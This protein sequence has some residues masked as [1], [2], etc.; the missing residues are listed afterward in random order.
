MSEQE[1][2]NAVQAVRQKIDKGLLEEAKQELDRLYEYKPVRLPWMVA[3]AEWKLKSGCPWKEVNKRL[4]PDIMYWGTDYEGMEKYKDYIEKTQKYYGEKDYLRK[5]YVTKTLRGEDVSGFYKEQETALALCEAGL[6][7]ESLRALAKSL[8]AV[9]ELAAYLIVA[10]ELER[11][12]W[13]PLDRNKEFMKWQNYGY[14]E[15]KLKAW[16]SGGFLLVRDEKNCRLISVLAKILAGMKHKVF[17]LET[18]STMLRQRHT[19]KFELL[20]SCLQG[21]KMLDGITYIP[22]ALVEEGGKNTGSNRAGIIDFICEGIPE[23]ENLIVLADGTLLD[24][25]VESRTLRR[26]AGRL[27]AVTH[28]AEIFQH[29]LQFGWA[30]KYL[31]FISDIYNYDVEKGMHEPSLYAFSIVIPVRNS[32]ATLKYALQ[33]CLRQSYQGAYEI[34]VSDNSVNGSSEIEEL[35]RE[36]G[37]ERIRYMKTPRDLPLSKSFEYAFLQARGEFLLSIGSDDGLLPWALE[38]L[39]SVRNTYPEE[40]IIQWY[41]GFYAWPGFNGGQQNMFVFPKQIVRG[42]YA[43]HYVESA[44]YRT[45]I[46]EDGQNV[47]LLPNLYINSGFSREYMWKLLKKTG[48]LWDGWNQDVYMGIMNICINDRILNLDYPLAIAGMSSGSMGYLNMAKKTTSEK[49]ASSQRTSIMM[50]WGNMGGHVFSGPERWL[51][52]VSNDLTVLANAVLRAVAYGVMSGEEAS[53]L[54]DFKKIFAAVYAN[55]ALTEEKFDRYLQEGRCLASKR[56]ADFTD[57]F[58]TEIYQKYSIPT[59]VDEALI[60]QQR[61]E[62]KYVEG[63][64]SEGGIILDGSK[65]GIQDIAGAVMLFSEFA[66]YGKEYG[67]ERTTCQ[68]IDS[69]L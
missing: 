10:L 30:G 2:L 42:E 17:V 46:A 56:G 18:P 26:K 34:I 51:P 7:K 59:I 65:K 47:Y 66:G 31:N 49:K 41:R 28:N 23:K 40:E 12:G 32:A 14:L 37:D 35:C 55:R 54:L 1:Y 45:L 58:L 33:T 61:N 62:K 50:H 15:M 21:S 19:D 39:D 63:A 44:S 25:L 67:C 9:D 27:S 52:D 22:T 69:Q 68:H 13:E 6:G 36:L 29:E 4:Y 20:E 3:E 24:T 16:G 11:Q 38:A 43:P 53:R 64:I 60:E 57:W 5:H 48:R 8:Y